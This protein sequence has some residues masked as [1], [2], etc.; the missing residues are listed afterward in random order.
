MLMNKE[1]VMLFLPHRDP[2]L[3]VDS[4]EEINTPE[5]RPVSKDEAPLKI[6]D[7]DLIG[8][9]VVCNFFTRE[10]LDIFRGHFPGKPILPG[11]VQVEMMAQSASFMIVN[12]I[13]D[14][15]NINL[16][17]ALMGVS[18][19][20]FRKPIVPNMNLRIES[21]CTRCRGPVMEYDCK[22]FND[23]ILMSEASVLASIRF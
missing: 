15:Q 20:K 5:I 7:K 18:K 13:K 17:V 10:D 19:A 8:S 14:P 12:Y 9:S 22:I 2:F 6:T 23:G 3:F 21:V 11:V 1:Q 16:D 4:V